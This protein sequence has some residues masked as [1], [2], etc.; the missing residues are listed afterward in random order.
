MRIGFLFN[1]DQV[2]QVRHS[3]PIGLA[4][5]GRDPELEPVFASTNPAI[6]AEIQRIARSLGHGRVPVTELTL[7]SGVSRGLDRLLGGVLPTRKLLVYRDN[8]PFFEGLDALVVSERTSLM[9]KTR[10]RMNELPILLADHGAGDR[11]IGF[12]PVTARFDHIL[13]AGDKIR[14]RLV[15]DAGVDPARITVTGYPKFDLAPPTPT[16]PFAANGRP[17]VLYNPHA[18][19]HLSSWYDMG[20]DVLDFF[21]RH[22]EY[23]LIFAPHVMLFQRRWVVSIDKLRLRRAGTIDPKYREAPNIFCDLASPALSDMSYTN[24]ADIYLGDVSSQ[25]YEF[26]RRPRPCVFL[27]ATG[28]DHPGDPN[29]AH[30]AAGLVIDDVGRLDAA[31]AQAV[32]VQP[33]FRQVQGELFRYTFDLTTEPSSTRAARAIAAQ[34]QRGRACVRVLAVDPASW[35]ERLGGHAHRPRR[36]GSAAV[37]RH[38]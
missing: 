4:L 37:R 31:L 14:D 29:F 36:T 25:V 9:L 1:H 30:W 7:R 32:A 19:P 3:L 5:V 38:A 8:L 15:R 16:L 10:Y 22:P 6:T 26:I 20:R 28:A 33:V 24:A 2:H 35:T 27:N 18:S 21:L 11:A 12:D 34:L 13:A 17:T 23:N